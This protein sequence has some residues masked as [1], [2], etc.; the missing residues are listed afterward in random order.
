MDLDAQV[1]LVRVATQAQADALRFAGSPTVNVNGRELEGYDGPGVLACRL[2]DEKG[3]PSRELLRQRLLAAASG[4]PAV[5]PK[6]RR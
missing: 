2:Y 5:Q 3:W 1:R 6:T 4:S